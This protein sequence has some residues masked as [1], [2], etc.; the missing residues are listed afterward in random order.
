MG[1]RIASS[2]IVIPCKM[3][4]TAHTQV[5]AELKAFSSQARWFQVPFTYVTLQS[6]E[7]P[8]GQKRTAPLCIDGAIPPLYLPTISK[9]VSAVV[10]R[11]PILLFLLPERSAQEILHLN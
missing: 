3:D 2:P 7:S 6:P 9:L 5:M 11:H 4:P 1:L 8:A 10:D